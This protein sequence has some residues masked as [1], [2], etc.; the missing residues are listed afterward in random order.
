[1]CVCVRE[2]EREHHEGPLERACDPQKDFGKFVVVI[3]RESGEHQN[4][5]QKH[6]NERGGNR[7]LQFMK[8]LRR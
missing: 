5:R 4:G 3:D 2:R 6:P 7:M 8:E 1:M